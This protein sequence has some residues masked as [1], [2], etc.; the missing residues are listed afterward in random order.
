MANSKKI[1]LPGGKTFQMPV[2]NSNTNSDLFLDALLT[3]CD[4]GNG[5]DT[6]HCFGDAATRGV[7][8][9]DCGDCC[10][11]LF[12]VADVTVV[13]PGVNPLLGFIPPANECLVLKIFSDGKLVDKQLAAEAFIPLSRIC[14]FGCVDVHADPCDPFDHKDPCDVCDPH[15]DDFCDK[16]DPCDDFCPDDHC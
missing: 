15:D 8:Q 14:S 12:N 7:V 6:N 16:K 13:I 2:G 1:S 4:N 10:K 11:F 5:N 3:F 9:F